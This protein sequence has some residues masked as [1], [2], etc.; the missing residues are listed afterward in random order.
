[1]AQDPI[2]F[3]PN[4]TDQQRSSYVREN[5]DLYSGVYDTTG[6]V[7]AT[8]TSGFET[9]FTIL[10]IANVGL[11]NSIVDIDIWMEELVSGG[12]GSFNFNYY[13]LPFTRFLSA[14]TVWDNAFSNVFY[15]A[16]GVKGSAAAYIGAVTLQVTYRNNVTSTSYPRF[17]YKISNRGVL[18]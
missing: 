15:N 11:Q 3:N 17:F 9:T 4:S 10:A 16:Q 12:G 18:A 1:M 5:R 8:K 7:L 13:K 14:G 6:Q 2:A